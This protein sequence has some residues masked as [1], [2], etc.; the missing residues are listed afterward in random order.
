MDLKKNKLH[1]GILSFKKLLC[2]NQFLAALIQFKML[3]NIRMLIKTRSGGFI[4]FRDAGDGEREGH[5]TGL[6]CFNTEHIPGWLILS[7]FHEHLPAKSAPSAGTSCSHNTQG[8][9]SAFSSP[10][11]RFLTRNLFLAGTA[12]ALEKCLH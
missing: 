12:S 4:T 7:L 1:N 6:G 8:V 2:K 9:K 11:F 10:E 3:Q 5:V